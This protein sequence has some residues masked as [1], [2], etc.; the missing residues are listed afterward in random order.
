M[1]LMR[2]QARASEWVET[3]TQRQSLQIQIQRQR[4]KQ[5]QLV[6]VPPHVSSSSRKA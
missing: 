3:D 5:R 4:Q 6:H 1:E 2:M